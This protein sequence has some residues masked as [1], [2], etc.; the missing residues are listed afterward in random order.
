M[1]IIFEA[2]DPENIRD[3][4]D[5][6]R[7][8]R[9]LFAP[10][11]SMTDAAYRCGYR[12]LIITQHERPNHGACW[13]TV[14]YRKSKDALDFVFV[15]TVTNPTAIKFGQVLFKAFREHIYV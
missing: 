6:D 15:D 9:F 7:F 3:Q 11:R 14:E 8:M 2:Y 10:I 4:D 13:F 1:T 12:P 5:V